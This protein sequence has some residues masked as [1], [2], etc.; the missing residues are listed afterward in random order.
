MRYVLCSVFTIVILLSICRNVPGQRSAS[1]RGSGVNARYTVVPT[2]SA[3]SVD[4]F[5]LLCFDLAEALRFVYCIYKCDT[6]L[7]AQTC[8][9]GKG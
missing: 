5:E 6:F 7:D 3:Q 9:T 1:T 4:L 8:K 2:I